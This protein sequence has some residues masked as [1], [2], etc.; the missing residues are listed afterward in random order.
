MSETQTQAARIIGKFKSQAALARELGR[1]PTTVQGWKDRGFIPAH[2]QQ[3]VLEAA[4]RLGVD[5][6]PADFFDA[7]LPIAG[8]A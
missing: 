3:E 7:P 2:H 1:P 8:A 4:H 5:L 6:A